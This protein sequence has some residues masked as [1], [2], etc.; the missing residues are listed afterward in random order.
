MV[1]S[2]SLGEA[3]LRSA[4]CKGIDTKPDYDTLDEQSIVTFLKARGLP[5]RIERARA[6]LFYVGVQVN[7]DRNEWGR[8]RVAI[9]GSPSQAGQELHEAVLAHGEGSWGIHRS[10]LAVLAPDG[11]VSDILAFVGRTK[12][13]CWGVLT[14]AGADDSFVVPGGYREL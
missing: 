14:I 6:D 10:N 13:A 8:L 1:D 5:V 2:L 4:V 3:R 7:P 11:T 9:L 12:L